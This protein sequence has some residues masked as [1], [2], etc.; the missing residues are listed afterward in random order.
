MSQDLIRQGR[1]VPALL[2]LT[3]GWAETAAR[4]GIDDGDMAGIVAE[5]ARLADDALAPLGAAADSEGAKV[6]DGR[7]ITPK[8]QPEAWRLLGENGWLAVDLAEQYGGQGL[9]TALHAA[10]SLAFEGAAMPFMM[11]AGSSRAGAH[12][13]AAAAPELAAAWG[14]KIASGEWHLTICISEPQAGSDV[15]RART[16]AAPDGDHWRISGKKCWI[17]FGDHDMADRIG[18]LCLARTGAPEEGTRGL[19]LFLV[20]NTDEDGAPN[21]IAVERIEEKLGL[22][23]SPTC[24]LN[25]E[26]AKATLIGQVGRGLPVMFN[27]IELMRLQTGAQGAGIALE[28][29][30]IAR[31]YAEDRAQGGRPDADPPAII[32]HPDVARMVL[33]IEADAALAT[34]MVLECALALDESRAKVEGAA[35][36][37][38]LLLPLAKTF[39]GETAFDCASAAIQ[40]LGGAGYTREWPVERH[41]RDARIITIYEGATGMQAQDFALRRVLRPD[42]PGLA[43]LLARMAGERAAHPDR[44]LAAR[45]SGIASRFEA[46]A[47]GLRD[48]R[49]ATVDR[50]GA[51]DALLR[52]GWCMMR[53]HLA[54]RLALL[55]EDGA[56]WAALTLHY[57][58]A[59]MTRAEAGTTIPAELLAV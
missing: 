32:T 29:A 5:A 19:S 18:H 30:K 6:V 24:V 22:H 4:A 1:L 2:A 23:G 14:P 26:N 51:A 41:L 53:A 16:R 8:G 13:L 3:P 20:A 9:P 46:L 15:G 17:S 21:G 27:M 38:A 57:A 58:D 42:A 50:L 48:E 33:G 39:G 54:L 10:A 49:V 55:G 47:E 36:R 12:L 56:R 59:E 28:C 25:F 31:A 40:V 44:A 34:A 37:A 7:V 35:E 52:A 43:A 11:A 45:A